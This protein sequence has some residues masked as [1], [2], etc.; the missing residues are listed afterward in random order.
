MD[1]LQR[2]GVERH[3]PDGERITGR[4]AVHRIPQHR[5]AQVGEV[6]ADLVRPPGA[7]L[8]LDQRHESQPLERTE[9]GDRSSP[10][11]SWCEGRPPRSRT[12]PADGAVHALLARKRPPHECHVPSPDAVSAE[13]PLKVLG[14]G[15]GER[16]HENARGLAVEAVHHVDAAV[17]P[18]PPLDLGP[19]PADDGVLLGIAGRVDEQS[20]GLVDDEDVR[21]DVD[22]LD[23]RD[24]RRGCPP[25]QA[26][27]VRDG[28]SGRDERAR[29]GHDD[30]VHEDVPDQHLVLGTGVGGFK[31]PL[32]GPGEALQRGVHARSVALPLS[33]T[34]DTAASSGVG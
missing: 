9:C 1:E 30:A 8:G 18:R 22:D 13:L 29:V 7:E 6:D 24:P 4:F 5:M 26:G 10:A 31:H 3:P 12:G 15:V 25:R 19:S 2:L 34:V 16:E 28:I 32:G 20:S 27:V 14:G 21:V 11:A 17:P 33:T 23:R